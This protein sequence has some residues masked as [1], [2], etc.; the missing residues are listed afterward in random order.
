MERL[1]REPD[2]ALG[3]PKGPPALF[4]AVQAARAA[5]NGRISNLDAMLAM[6]VAQRYRLAV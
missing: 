2:A 5:S 3:D 1:L 4:D 6:S